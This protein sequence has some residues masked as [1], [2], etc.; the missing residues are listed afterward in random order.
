[1]IDVKEIPVWWAICQNR[2]CKRAE[3][4]LRYQAFRS[5]PKEVGSWKCI[6]P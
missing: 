2:E 3:E 5:M 6:L 4:C 1:M